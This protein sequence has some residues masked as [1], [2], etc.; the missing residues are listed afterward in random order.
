MLK[1]T[2]CLFNLYFE[3]LIYLQS[4]F[5]FG[6]CES[7]TC[8]FK[9]NQTKH[10]IVLV[11]HDQEKCSRSM[12]ISSF[13][14]LL[15]ILLLCL[16]S[17]TTTASTS[18]RLTSRLPT[19]SRFSLGCSGFCKRE[20]NCWKKC[21]NCCHSFIL[22]KKCSVKNCG[23]C[24]G[25]NCGPWPEVCRP[26]YCTAQ[27]SCYK[28]CSNC[29]RNGASCVRK[30]CH[31]T[32]YLPGCG[33]IKP[34]CT[35]SYCSV[36]NGCFR[37][38]TRCCQGSNCTYKSCSA[39]YVDGVCR[40]L[41]PSPS[42]TPSRAPILKCNQE[43]IRESNSCLRY[44]K[45]CCDTA[46]RCKISNC[47]ARCGPPNCPAPTNPYPPTSTEGMHTCTWVCRRK[48]GCRQYCRRCCKNGICVN[49]DHCEGNCLRGR[50]CPATKPTEEP[51]CA[52]ECVRKGACYTRCRCC[53]LNGTCKNTNL[54]QRAC[55]SAG[56]GMAWR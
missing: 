31:G 3:K 10:E 30:N 6:Y 46:G 43:C 54:C 4:G 51:V 21:Q 56:C 23:G 40:V 20:G 14:G 1:N 50:N 37:K 49:T 18:V 41:K 36:Q 32:C 26:N 35:N 22:F 42:P 25:P 27:G 11:L 44:C 39:C 13:K 15:I 19:L 24:L 47:A 8:T 9:L 12:K 16:F 34:S 45:K 38:C 2:S 7:I 33:Q 17:S 53:C 48:N 52:W 29:C 5:H 55:F 28:K